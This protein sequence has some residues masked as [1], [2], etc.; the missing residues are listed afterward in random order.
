MAAEFAKPETI[1]FMVRYTSG[2]ICVSV[3]AS[4]FLEPALV[5]RE[6]LLGCRIHAK[7]ATE[8][9]ALLA[10]RWRTSVCRS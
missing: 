8:T 7:T 5:A 4:A 1:G 9:A 3:S 2:V 10:C 6:L